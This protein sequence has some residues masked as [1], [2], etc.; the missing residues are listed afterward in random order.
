MQGMSFLLPAVR[1]H[2]VRWD[3]KGYP[4]ALAGEDIPL[5][6][7]VISVAKDFDKF[8]ESAAVRGEEISTKDAI[9]GLTAAGVSTYDPKVLDALMTAHTE[10]WLYEP[11][12]R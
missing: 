7:R 4:D 8:I 2:R 5:E 3:G 12:E 11:P 9:A 6:A 10:G 1:H